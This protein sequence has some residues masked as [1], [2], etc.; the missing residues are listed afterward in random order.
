MKMAALKSAG[1]SA[2]GTAI[3]LS[4]A[5]SLTPA[6]LYAPTP[7][8]AKRVLEF[9]TAQINN[10]HTRLAYLNATRRFAEWCEAH[11]LRQL[12]EVQAFHVAAF[13]KD[14]QDQFSPPTVKVHLA[15]IRMLFDWLVTGHIM[16]VNPAH[17]VRG[18]K[19]VVKKG[20][21]PILNTEEAR[22]L[23]DSID[24]STLIGMRD[25][26]II[27][28][29]VYTFARVNAVIEMKV[30]DYFTQ[31]RRGWVRLHEKGGKEHEVPCHHTLE[32]YL[33]EYLAAAGIV[34][35]PEGPL[36]RSVGRKTGR[37]EALWQQDVFRMIQRRAA[38]AN[39]ATKIGNH[40]FRATGITAYLK[41][42]GLLEHAQTIANH[43][44]PRT[45]KLYDRRSDEISLDEIE[46]IAI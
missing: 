39:I 34:G 9:F 2:T 19:Y 46:K 20:K 3:V 38:A 28:M 32:K 5:P 31:G 16:E 26:A 22:T 4:P 21:T 15:A 43:S 8:A 37:A 17:A 36:F 44:S 24:T 14:L 7:K 27:G 13:V 45:T 11:E 25:R 1:L 30:K 18:P 41:N 29:M 35:E 42:G 23:L 33:D 40:T 6:P 10:D 12:A